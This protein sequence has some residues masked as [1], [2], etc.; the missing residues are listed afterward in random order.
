MN[1]GVINDGV[2]KNGLC[3]IG[4]GGLFSLTALQTL[5]A[6]QIQIHCII[7]AG[8][9]PATTPRR[10]LSISPLTTTTDTPG[11]T[12][13]TIPALAVQ[14][15]I[16]IHYAGHDIRQFDH[17]PDWPNLAHHRRPEF[18]FVACFPLRLPDALLQWPTRMAINLHPSL[19]P[20]YRGP[21]PIFWQLRNDERH[22]GISLHRLTDALDAGPILI[23]KR[24]SFPQGASADELDARLAQQGTE[25]LCDTL[26]D[27]LCNANSSQT[28]TP[29]EQDPQTATYQPLPRPED[30]ELDT[31]W[32]AE[33]A[34]N[35]MR[36]TRNPFGRYPILLDGQWH[37]LHSAL[38]F[39]KS[40]SLGSSYT[41]D[42][43]LPDSQQADQNRFQT[44]EALSIQFS[45]GVLR[46]KPV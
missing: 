44:H 29:H 10:G 20:S 43:S 31:R 40:R 1:D 38:S 41:R 16:P 6:R 9:A 34:Y 13:P 39:D 30:Y 12:A 45:P 27:N 46:A 24:V 35:F 14:L 3:F 18:L 25:A 37:H 22:T 7:L 23:Q 17:W 19:L 8:Y 26:C 4:S 33:H 32:S 2:I 5:L 21:N 11:N 28:L 15:G 42:I 36:G